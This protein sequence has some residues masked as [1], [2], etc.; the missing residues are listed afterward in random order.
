[1]AAIIVAVAAGPGRAGGD[2][3]SPEAKSAIVDATT[4]HRKV[5]CGYQ[6]WF[7][8]PGDL[9][10]EGWR[11]WSRDSKKI[12]PQTLTVEMW[13][14]TSELSAEERYE[15]KG[16]TLGDDKPACL[17][18]SANAKTVD[19]HFEWMRDYGIDGAFVQ[20]FLVSRDSPSV[21]KVLDNVRASAAKTGRTYAI[22]Y[23]LTDAPKDE[24]FDRLIAD[25]KRLVD[26]RKVTQDD[27]Y[28]RHEGKPVVFV[29]GFFS[30]RFG[31]ALAHRI[32]DLF[33]TDKQY[34]AT[35][36]GGCQWQWRTEKDAEW[37]KAFRR[38]DV[39]SPWNVGNVTI[40]D[41]KKH[42]ATGYWKDDLAETKKVG[43]AYLPVIY[44]GFG[45]TNLK[46][47]GAAVANVPRLGGEFFWRQFVTAA[48]LGIDMAYVAMFDEVDEAT[49]IFK[50]ANDPPKE[51]KFATFDGLPTDW[52]LR[53]T[54]EGTMV[55]RGEQ[56]AQTTLP[57]KP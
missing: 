55:I 23:D 38:F 6:G 36:I 18:S 22:C 34:G 57:I 48:D 8:C 13:P 44:P 15:A 7:R 33:K 46:G 37:A 56:K 32:I 24:L 25:W 9:A 26:E 5:M 2:E 51:A 52:Y 29:W 40:A 17:F 16:F 30:E 45:W 19:R 1:M 50:V 31:P 41:G 10:G 20:R 27:R 43:M 47:K 42:A 35:L 49:A 53:L 3:R 54:G 4:M 12:S 14:D 28:L 39:I 21:D 11:H